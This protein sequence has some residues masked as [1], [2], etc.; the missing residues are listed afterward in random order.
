MV[1]P[2]TVVLSCT[3]AADCS[4]LAAGHA[5][6]TARLYRAVD[7]VYAENSSARLL[8]RRWLARTAA[9]SPNS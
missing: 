9:D 7:T 3:D 2:Y 4:L 5:E 6:K 1:S 8:A